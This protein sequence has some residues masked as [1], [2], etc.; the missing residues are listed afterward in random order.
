MDYAANEL[1][2]Q[3]LPGNELLNSIIKRCDD[4]AVLYAI[5]ISASDVLGR[6]HIRQRQAVRTQIIAMNDADGSSNT[7][8]FNNISK[9]FALLAKLEATNDDMDDALSAK[10]VI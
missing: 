4:N 1:L 6:R 7:D 9:L 3:D 5:T 10:G 8:Y 2:Q